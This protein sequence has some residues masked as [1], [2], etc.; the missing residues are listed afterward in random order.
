ML[1][2][3]TSTGP[4]ASRTAAFQTEAIDPIERIEAWVAGNL[5]REGGGVP[6]DGMD[7]WHRRAFEIFNPRRTELKPSQKALDSAP[8]WKRV[9]VSKKTGATVVRLRDKSLVKESD[10]QELGEEL[11]DLICAGH[12]RLVIDFSV[13]ERLSCLVLPVLA[14]AANLCEEE[15]GGLLKVVNLRPELLP[16]VGLSPLTSSFPVPPDEST[17]LGGP[18]PEQGPRPLPQA[19]LFGLNSLKRKVEEPL[20]SSSSG[21]TTVDPVSPPPALR[22][23]IPCLVVAEGRSTGRKVL[24]G[25]D[26]LVIGRDAECRV[27]SDHAFLSRKHAFVR[28][29][30]VRAW[31]RDL[32]S[33]NG[34]SLNGKPLGR[35][36]VEVFAGDRLRIGPFKFLISI[37]NSRRSSIDEAQIVN[38]VGHDSD[39]EPTRALSSSETAYEVPSTS[40]PLRIEVIQD[41]VV[42][43][44]LDP[45]LLQT[46]EPDVIREE[47][48]ALIEGGSSRRVVLNLEHA[49]RLSNATL[50]LL[51]AFHLRLDRLGGALRLCQPHVRI[52]QF[53][54][55]IRLPILLD[56]FPTKEEAVLSSWDRPDGSADRA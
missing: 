19:L 29:D 21:I 5:D 32:A 30:G 27:R 39:E 50:G 31:V 52:A 47:L 28:S 38:W 40:R 37:D 10:L 20:M 24:I 25:E 22:H 41:V 4:T 48:S 12:R 9:S 3:T 46:A 49:G 18:W 17:A 11:I 6:G 54:E 34:T 23:Q 26:G 7:D 1:C 53:L 15:G 43:T 14:N 55:Q 8:G 33:T 16:V 42:V 44:P 35:A 56:I 45:N 13:V 2:G 36:E 51:V